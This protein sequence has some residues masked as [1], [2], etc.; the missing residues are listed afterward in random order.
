MPPT[1][2]HTKNRSGLRALLA[3][4]VF[5]AVIYIFVVIAAYHTQSAIIFR[6]GG[7]TAHHPPGF[8][9]ET[10]SIATADGLHLTGWWLPKSGTRRTVLFFQ[11]NRHQASDHT[12]RLKTLTELGVNALLFDYRGFGLTAGRIH[13]EDDIYRDGQAAW[14]YLRYERRI[15]A[16]DIIL[17]GRSLGGAVAVEVARHRPV[18]ALVLE[19]T[20]YTLD[21]MARLHYRWLPTRY[22]LKFHFRN[23]AKLQDVRA[24]I[25]IIHSPVDGYIPFAQGRRLFEEAPEPKVFLT[26]EGHHLELFDRHAIYRQQVI[27][28]LNRLTNLTISTAR[29]P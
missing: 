15:P 24:P 23:G 22:L 29:Q 19:S 9:I 17:W 10:V 26:T 21:E 27:N 11:G 1:H 25:I 5:G 14:D 3:C 7:L 8:L 6:P 16:E 2:I 18:G 28:Q 13:S 4:M 12:L 20:F